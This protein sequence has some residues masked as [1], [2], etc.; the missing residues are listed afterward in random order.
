MVGRIG[1]IKG[2]GIRGMGMGM[3]GRWMSW[4]RLAMGILIGIGFCI[5]SKIPV[6]N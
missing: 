6:L 3:G 4:G 1:R 2:I 5:N